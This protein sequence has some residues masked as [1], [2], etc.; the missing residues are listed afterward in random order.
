MTDVTGKGNVS[1]SSVTINNEGFLK[2]AIFHVT[3]KADIKEFSREI[4]KENAK[5]MRSNGV[6]RR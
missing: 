1:T 2:G 4:A 5:V 3:E 6:I